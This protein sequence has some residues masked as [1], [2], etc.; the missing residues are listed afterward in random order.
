MD[1]SYFNDEPTSDDID[2]AC[3][4]A[5][6]C[7]WCDERISGT[8]FRAPGGEPCCS[9]QCVTKWFLGPYEASAD[10]RTLHPTAELIGADGVCEYIP[11][12][13]SR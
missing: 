13:V 1:H 4:E 5:T 10:Y 8:P 7:V 6:R 3:E 9:P 12:E 2:R 11:M